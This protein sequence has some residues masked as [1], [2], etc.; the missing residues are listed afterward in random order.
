[1]RRAAFRRI[2]RTS[3]NR[4]PFLWRKPAKPGECGR[5]CSRST[6]CKKRSER[7]FCRSN[8]L[9]PKLLFRNGQARRDAR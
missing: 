5:V 2:F 7:S 4:T 6:A 3:E 8:S 9:A 1:M